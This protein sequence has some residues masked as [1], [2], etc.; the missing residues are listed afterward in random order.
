MTQQENMRTD[1]CQWKIVAPKGSKINITFTSLKMLQKRNTYLSSTMQS[2]A[3]N[4]RRNNT[5]LTVST[6]LYVYNT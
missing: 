2:M 4:I 5:Q 6:I 3:A 1:K